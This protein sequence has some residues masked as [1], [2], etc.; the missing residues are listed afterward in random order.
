MITINYFKD[1]LIVEGHANYDVENKDI[2][3]AGVSAIVMGAINW[4]E[5]SDIKYKINDGYMHFEIINKTECNL[6]KLNL[7]TIQLLSLKQK[8]YDKYL[9]FV[10][11][12][13]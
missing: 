7:I 12:T 9:K 11:N 6:K 2:I 4:F 1:K 3:C 8:K 5:S 13:K 10:D